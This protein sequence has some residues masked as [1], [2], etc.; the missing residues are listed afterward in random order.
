MFTAKTYHFAES[1]DDAFGLLQKNKTNTI[2]GGCG[3]LRMTNKRIWT[4]IDLGRLG[5]DQIE[6]T[7]EAVRLGASVTLRQLETCPAL[8]G[9]FG[10]ILPESVRHIVGV[11]FRNMATVGASVFM[12]AGYSDLCAA[13][14][15]L[16]ASVVLHV[17]GEIPFAQFLE[18]P[19]TRDI[20]THVTIRKD[21]RKA[22]Y[23]SLRLS[24][25]DFPVLAVA[26]SRLGDDWRVSVGARP[27]K[28]CRAPEA[29]RQLAA[30][31]W[32]A[33]GEAAA[34]ELRFETNLRGSAEYRR[35]I[36]PVLVQ[37]A[38]KKLMEGE[39]GR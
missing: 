7:P 12:R 15:A 19:Y 37:R 2:L 32:A 20:L 25:T 3:W 29:E 11:Q 1:L 17:G 23:E 27:G 26:V 14:L 30:G 38:V 5:L 39:S 21:G 35:A 22:A 13:L 36:T 8:R 31:A 18:M 24:A 4:A 6:E 10:G 28:A 9:A 33:A 16:D 34:H